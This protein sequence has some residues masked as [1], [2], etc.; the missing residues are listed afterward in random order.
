[1]Q[2]VATAP[3]LRESPAVLC[4]FDFRSLAGGFPPKTPKLRLDT[5][6]AKDFDGTSIQNPKSKIEIQKSPN[7][8]APPPPMS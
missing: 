5:S 1:M 7:R 6:A 2:S 4:R 3:R 8:L